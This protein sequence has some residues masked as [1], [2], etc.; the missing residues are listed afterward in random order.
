MNISTSLIPTG[1][2]PISSFES[3]KLFVKS[4]PTIT[5]EEEKLLALKFQNSNCLVSAQKLIMSQLKTVL[6]LASKYSGYGLPMEDLVQEGNIGVMKAVKNFDTKYKVRLYTYSKIWITS[7][8]QSYILKNWKIVKIATTKNLKKLF[9]NFKSI[10]REMINL[11][12][13]KNEFIKNI[14][15]KLD[16]SEKEARE[17][18]SYFSTEDFSFNSP[19]DSDDEHFDIPTFETPE[20]DY[21]NKYDSEVFSNK[22]KEGI[23]TLNPNQKKVLEL[24]YYSEDKPTHKDISK[25]LHVSSERVRQIENEALKKLQQTIIE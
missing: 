4:L 3:Y 20:S 16:V 23:K 14:S 9:F 11:G 21:Q 15:L 19:S 1:M 6:H 25:I 17:M 5:E 10:Q 24:R 7:E 22:L 12:L 13:P 8:I 18:Q 2:P